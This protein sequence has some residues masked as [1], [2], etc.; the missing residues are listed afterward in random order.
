M[1]KCPKCGAPCKTEWLP[2]DRFGP[3]GE[4][5]YRYKRPVANIHASEIER[6]SAFYLNLTSH[7][8]RTAQALQDLRL[9]HQH[10]KS[11]L[12]KKR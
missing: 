11:L 6:I 2:S 7:R 3:G 5:S 12:R 10:A 4:W 9:I 8:P 1:A